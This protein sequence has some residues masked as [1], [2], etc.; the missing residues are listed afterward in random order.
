MT[1]SVDILISFTNEKID[2]SSA[3]RFA[4]DIELSGISFLHIKIS[5]RPKVSAYLL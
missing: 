3:K 1:S 5:S 2:L 4:V